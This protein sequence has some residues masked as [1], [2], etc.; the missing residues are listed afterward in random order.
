VRARFDS[1]IASSCFAIASAIGIVGAFFGLKLS[2]FWLDELF[3]AWIVE[4]GI[5]FDQFVARFVTDVHPPVYYGLAYA[6]AQLFGDDE[7]GLRSLSA[8]LAGLAIVLFVTSTA[9]YFSLAARLF[10]SAMATGS[11]FWFYHSQNA[12]GYSLSFVIGTGILALSLS[13]IDKRNRPDART[14]IDLAGLAGLMVLGSFV[15]F[16]LMYECLAVLVVL[17]VFCPRHRIFFMALGAALLVSTGAY[18]KIVVEVFSQY[19]TTTNWIHGDPA[20]YV[21]QLH[22]AFVYS[23]TNK[24]LLALAIC[25]GAW[26]SQRFVVDRM[27][28]AASAK[29]GFL[30]A[31]RFPLDAQT[32]LFA[33]VPVVVFIG[34]VASSL[35]IAP[36]FTDR[37]LLV[38]SP[39]LWALSAKLYDAGVP[40]A[41][42][43]LRVAANLMLSAV[44][45]W[46]AVTM[47][48]GRTRLWKEPF[49]ETAEWIKTFPECR[50][51]PIMVINA[52]PRAWFKPGYAEIL[53]GDFYATYLNE[54]ARP[55]VIFMEDILAHKLPE[56]V[57]EYLR[58]RV[59]GNGCPVLAWSIH[60]ITEK[61]FEQT[62]RE[63]LKAIGRP[64]A[65]GQVQTKV[66]YDLLPGYLLRADR[67]AVRDPSQ[68]RDSKVPPAQRKTSPAPTPSRPAP[69][70]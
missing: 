61:E 50:D 45:I 66:L 19:T 59:D 62:W 31:G 57:K 3:T 41:E 23:F 24:A 2:S 28:V 9:R 53:Y 64:D 7:V 14:A 55:Q 16:Y 34:G 6:Y 35:L 25:I 20:W 47:V 40:H 44:A 21:E 52:Q 29:P 63:L 60:L 5:T 11:F 36:N 56:D 1:L 30:L 38:C 32:A 17:W 46:M 15:H 42:R 18:V 33:G 70:N 43:R 68:S 65:I 67:A 54:F 51:Q 22:S 8:V 39:F 58:S 12:R 4:V 10:G 49:R 69:R 37:N 48:A 26:L 13:L 27:G